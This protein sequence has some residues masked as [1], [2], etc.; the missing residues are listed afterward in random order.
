MCPVTAESKNSKPSSK[1]KFNKK[2][3]TNLETIV[4]ED[5]NRNIQNS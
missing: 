5:S 3:N 1:K 2:I 4:E